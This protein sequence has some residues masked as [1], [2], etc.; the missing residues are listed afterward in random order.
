M[1]TDYLWEMFPPYRLTEDT[2]VIPFKHY[3]RKEGDGFSRI[4]V[5]NATNPK[6]AGWYEASRNHY[7][8]FRHHCDSIKV[9]NV[10][11]IAQMTLEYLIGSDNYPKIKPGFPRC[12]LPRKVGEV[13]YS[14]NFHDPMFDEVVGTTP[15][16]PFAVTFADNL[17][18]AQYA[19]ALAAKIAANI[20]S[21]ET[22]D[23]WST[24]IIDAITSYVLDGYTFA[25]VPPNKTYAYVG[26]NLDMSTLGDEGRAADVFTLFSLWSGISW[27]ELLMIFQ[28]AAMRLKQISDPN[29]MYY[30]NSLV[31]FMKLFDA[32]A[33]TLVH[34]A[35]LINATIIDCSCKMQDGTITALAEKFK[36]RV[37]A[38]IPASMEV[39]GTRLYKVE[40]RYQLVPNASY[41]LVV[42]DWFGNLMPTGI[43]Q[44][45]NPAVTLAHLPVADSGEFDMTYAL[46]YSQI[47]EG[48]LWYTNV[49]FQS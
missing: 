25:P 19:N 47:Q 16:P 1:A 44:L 15:V 14:L 11:V 20:A 36:E 41:C 4:V 6:A 46:P 13:D 34:M 12:I 39:D 48:M 43:Q 18:V 7:E 28:D 27:R 32:S 3:F 22:V 17:W 9:N 5:L 33:R 40:F 31:E 30:Y 29:D 10:G 23:D 21:I 24:K 38:G 26:Y 42:C 35:K 37:I 8:E 49:P 2:A 45:S